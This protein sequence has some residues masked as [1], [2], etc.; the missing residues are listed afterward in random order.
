MSSTQGDGLGEVVA[1]PLAA[2]I[3]VRD[4]KKK[5]KVQSSSG[6]G[7]SLVDFKEGAHPVQ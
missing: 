2:Y 1:L 7:L 6:A 3:F 5:A 4:K